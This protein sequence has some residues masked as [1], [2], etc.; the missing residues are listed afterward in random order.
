MHYYS[1]DTDCNKKTVIYIFVLSLLLNTPVNCLFNKLY[2][3]IKQYFDFLSGTFS[4][5]N[6]LGISI[7]QISVFGIFGIIYFLYS[8]WFWKIKIFQKL[9]KIPNLNGT[10]EGCL[11]STYK[12]TTINMKME[13]KQTCDKI[14]FKSIFENSNSYSKMA[15]IHINENEGVVIQ[16]AYHNNTKEFKL[17]AKEYIGYNKL[18]YKD[19][20]LCGPYF[21]NRENGTQGII[22][23]KR[24]QSAQKEQVQV[25]P[26]S[27]SV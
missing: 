14:S 7:N 21:T 23:L 22:I 18:V 2:N 5:F 4:E 26:N 15:S 24:N 6:L 10:W 19:D 20:T 13:I 9:H 8:H 27:L 17:K 1:L 25:Q 3:F 12:N 16:F 11:N